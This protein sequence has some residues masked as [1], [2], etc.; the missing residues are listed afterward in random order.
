RTASP[1]A[2]S[3]CFHAS[4]PTEIYILSLHDALPICYIYQS[5]NLISHLTVLDNVLVAL[6]MTTLTKEERRKR[7]LELLDKVGLSEQVK[8]HPN[9]LSGEKK[10][11]VAIARALASDPQIII[12]DEPTG[13]LDAQ[14]TKEVL[15]LLD[16]IARD[17]KLVIAVTHSQEVADNGT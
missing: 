4:A 9:H 1:R 8:K 5:Y 14:N 13:A 15:A 2:S 12:A 17:G 6:D 16:E 11:R 10:Q 7:A 3:L